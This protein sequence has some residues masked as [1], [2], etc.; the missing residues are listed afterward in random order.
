MRAAHPPDQPS[1]PALLSCLVTTCACPAHCCD[2]YALRFIPSCMQTDV[3]M[4]SVNIWYVVSH[5]HQ[6]SY[7][8][9]CTAATAILYSME[10][11]YAVYRSV[12]DQPITDLSLISTIH[13]GLVIRCLS[14]IL[15]VPTTLST[16]DSP[17]P[18]VLLFILLVCCFLSPTYLHPCPSCVSFD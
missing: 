1:P 3:L 6:V 11:H 18:S 12:L 4:I 2:R 16:L 9:L 10:I 7:P 14:V 13:T 15:A 5:S 17:G 8:H